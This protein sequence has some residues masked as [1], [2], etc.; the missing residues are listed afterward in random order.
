MRRLWLS[1]AAILGKAALGLG[2]VLCPVSASSGVAQVLALNQAQATILVSGATK[3]ETLQLPFHW[4]RANPGQQGEAFF[5]FRFDLPV[6]PQ[7]LWGIYLPRLGNAYEIWLNGTLLQHG[8]D[9]TAYD[10]ADFARVPRYISVDHGHFQLSNHLQIHIRADRGRR[11][12]LA[13]PVIGP[14]DLVYPLYST[15]YHWRATGSIAVMAFCFVVGLTALALSTA[16]AMRTPTDQARLD[17][18]FIF[19]AVAQLFWALYVADVLIEDPPLPWPWWGVVQVV[20]L[21]IWGCSM[22]LALSLIHI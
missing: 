13:P 17:P 20:A 15:N 5:D 22:A 4:D 6:A 1:V 7:G 9:L 19:A 10:G 16:A 14:E 18:L 2:L 21:G 8:G 12:G 11:G 3:Q